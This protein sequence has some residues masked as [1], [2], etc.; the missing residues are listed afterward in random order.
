MRR[1]LIYFESLSKAKFETELQRIVGLYHFQ[2][3]KD[4]SKYKNCLYL[5]VLDNYKQFYVGKSVGSLSSRM[6]KHWMAKIIPAREL[7]HGGYEHSRLKYDDFKILDNTRIYVCTEI[8]R[9]VEENQ[10]LANN[11]NIECTNLFSLE[12]YENMDNL[13]KAERIVIDDCLCMFCLSDRTPL[14][15][16]PIYEKRFEKYNVTKETIKIWHYI[17]LDEHKVLERTPERVAFIKS[18]KKKK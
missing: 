12:Y 15:D 16:C 1:N 13:D 7:W 10:N 4:L 2:E 3:T 6:R 5:A 8:D 11:P 18:L 17:M 14:L 9:V